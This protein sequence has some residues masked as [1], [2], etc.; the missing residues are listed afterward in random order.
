ML[1]PS[2]SSPYTCNM[3]QRFY[4]LQVGKHNR[5]QPYDIKE[6]FSLEMVHELL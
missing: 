1:G 4:L 5:T 3:S 6:L 2:W